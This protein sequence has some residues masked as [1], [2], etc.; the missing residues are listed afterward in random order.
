MKKKKLNKKVVL[1]LSIILL[2]IVVEVINPI[3]LYNKYQLR[4]LGYSDTSIT[5]ILKNGLKKDIL[6]NKYSKSLDTV[7][8]SSDFNK[9]NY[10]IYKKINYYN[11]KDY[12]KSI[13][14]LLKKGYNKEDIENILR[15]ATDSSI[16]EFLKKDYDKNVSSYLEYD[17]A[18]LANYDRYLEYNK[19]NAIDKDKIVTYVNI[20]LDKDFYT[21]TKKVK[22]FSFD[23]LVNKYNE[24]DSSFIPDDLVSV[25][26]E[27]AVDDK[28]KA[29]KT[30]LE[31]FKKMSDDCKSAVG[32]KIVI[33]SGYRDYQNQQE[34]YDLYLN[35][36]GK[37]YAENYVAHPGFSEH[38]TGLAADIKAE[39]SETFEG[40]PESKWLKENA[41]KYGFIFRYAKD[42]V[43][44][45]G[46]RYES[47]HYRY[48]GEELANKVHESGLTYDEYYIRNLNK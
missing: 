6:E 17:Y 33:R 18:I 13:N 28:Q 16:T 7:L 26:E 31:A 30:M 46:I 14:T 27:Y 45:T 43:K 25:P 21:D 5:T 41:Y 40:T 20:G 29:N 2:I 11:L 32:S 48:V 35:T 19:E 12:T 23:M 22:E 34:T 9:D 4:E 47:W 8:A 39:S 3:K 37:N 36:Y 10:E 1:I 15:S 38:Q 42:T 24:L 44:I